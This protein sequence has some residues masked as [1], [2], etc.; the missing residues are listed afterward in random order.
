[1]GIVE[2]GGGYKPRSFQEKFDAGS[3]GGN[4]P[5]GESCKR[6]KVWA[7]RFIAEL[8]KPAKKDE[9][10]PRS[11]EK[12]TGNHFGGFGGHEVFPTSYIEEQERIRDQLLQ[13]NSDQSD[14]SPGPNKSLAK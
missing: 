5:G 1:M 10:Q 6:I 3:R 4:A 11:A 2:Q 8:N 12:T 14:D 9:G 13:G 7:K